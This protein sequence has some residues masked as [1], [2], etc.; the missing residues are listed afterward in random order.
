MFGGM[1]ALFK[2]NH[3]GTL[4]SERKKFWLFCMCPFFLFLR[5]HVST[6]VCVYHECVY[7]DGIASRGVQRLYRIDGG[8]DSQ[9]I[10]FS[11]MVPGGQR[12]QQQNAFKRHQFRT[13]QL[14]HLCTTVT[15]KQLQIACQ[16]KTS[17]HYRNVMFHRNILSSCIMKTKS[18]TNKS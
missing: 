9:P 8:G 3:L 17:H 15:R 12:E 7:V 11:L 10:I 5:M 4:I 13:S 18:L 2:N 14:L 1:D 6:Y 16:R